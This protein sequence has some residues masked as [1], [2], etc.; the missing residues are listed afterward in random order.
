MT[1]GETDMLLRNY[2]RNMASALIGQKDTINV[3]YQGSKT[4]T[5]NDG[6]LYGFTYWGS[7][8]SSAF[9]WPYILGLR[10]SY[11]EYGGVIIG[12]GDTPPTIDDYCLS[13]DLITNFTYSSSATKTIDNNQASI[14][15]LYTI[16]N[17]GSDAFTIR[18]IALKCGNT[19][20]TSGQCLVERTVLDTPVTIEPGGV[21]QITYTITFTYPTA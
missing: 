3:N 9:Q 1:W 14:R 20:G 4:L 7:S 21:G 19:T 15:V 12:T 17:S 11:T 18:E 8:G 13:G 16:T 2:Y 6:V 10:K 5:C